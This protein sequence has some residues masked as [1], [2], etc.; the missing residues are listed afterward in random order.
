MAIDAVVGLIGDL[1]RHVAVIG[2]LEAIATA[3]VMRVADHFVFVHALR[4]H[5]MIED[6]RLGQSKRRPPLET[7]GLPRR[8]GPLHEKI[9]ELVYRGSLPGHRLRRVDVLGVKNRLDQRCT[10]CEQRLSQLLQ[11]RASLRRW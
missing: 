4:V 9:D 5:Q 3:K 8:R 11:R 7:A 10:R 1:S 2:Q 6:Q